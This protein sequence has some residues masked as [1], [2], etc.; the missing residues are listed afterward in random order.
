MGLGK[1]Q[2]HLLALLGAPAVMLV[3]PDRVSRSLERRGLVAPR[4]TRTDGFIGITL[5]GLRALADLFE[6]GKLDELVGDPGKHSNPD[7]SRAPLI[8][9]P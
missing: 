8:P 9:D 3:V 4:G 2:I 6:A 5:A 1:H 7:N